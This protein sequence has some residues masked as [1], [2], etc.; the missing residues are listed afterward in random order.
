SIPL[1]KGWRVDANNAST[2]DDTVTAYAVCGKKHAGYAQVSGIATTVNASSQGSAD[3]SCPTGTL[4][5]SGGAFSSS[6][7]TQV[8]LNSTLPV[9][10]T[11]WKSYEDNGSSGTNTVTA[12]A[13]CADAH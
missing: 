8:N 12:Y 1:T 11:D 5:L 7:S 9:S 6:G 4:V 10:T 13:V 2:G 3:A